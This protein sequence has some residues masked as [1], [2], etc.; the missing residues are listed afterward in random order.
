MILIFS[1]LEVGVV[2]YGFQSFCPQTTKP[3]PFNRGFHSR[4]DNFLLVLYLYLF[5]KVFLKIISKIWKY[6][7]LCKCVLIAPQLNQNDCFLCT[8]METEALPFRHKQ[9]SQSVSCSNAR[10]KP[11][12]QL[13]ISLEILSSEV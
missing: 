13:T 11:E 1:A 8:A 2:Y 4:K 3:S 10:A 12:N 6:S 7:L 5:L 9:R